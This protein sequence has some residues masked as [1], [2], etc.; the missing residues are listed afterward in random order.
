[1]LKSHDAKLSITP[2]ADGQSFI[3]KNMIPGEFQY[4]RELQE[5]LASC[6]N[7]RTVMDTIPDFELF[8]LP[9]SGW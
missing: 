5:P 9:L 4:Q 7:L 6:P 1:M 8:V 2:S 3:I